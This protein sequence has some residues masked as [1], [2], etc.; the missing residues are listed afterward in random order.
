MKRNTFSVFFFLRKSRVN[1]LGESPIL[2]RITVNGISQESVIHRNVRQEVWNQSAERAKGNDRYSF[3]IN[4]YVDTV[5]TRIMQIHRQM[6]LDGKDITAREIK[7]TFQGNGARPKM[8]LDQFRKHNDQCRRLIDTEY[9]PATV[10]RFD[11]VVRYLGEFMKTLYRIEDI[12]FKEINH[13]FI[14]NYAYFLKTEKNLGHN[15]VVKQLKCLKKITR[16]AQ[17]NDWINKDPF[18]NYKLRE[19]S[20]ERDFLEKEEIDLILNRQLS[21]ERLEQVRDV[22]IFCAFTGLAF[23]DVKHLKP[24]HLVKGKGGE[25]WLR[26]ARQKTKN[27]CDI[28]LLQI[29]IRI[30]EKYRENPKCLKQG[31]L[32]PVLCN[33]RMNG[34]LKEIADLCG[35]RKNL[36]THM[37]RHTFATIALTHGMS[38]ESVA[39]MLGHSRIEQTKHYARILDS[40]ISKEMDQLRTVFDNHGNVS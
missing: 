3:E 23:T 33:Q 11:R 30:L 7:E 12:M 16:M 21:V 27:M 36:T 6:E 5:R 14:S 28:P 4:A 2:V 39:K 34:Y 40:K 20:T 37:A 15:A 18:M 9:S 10:S 22:F 8:L 13:E 1:K 38:I 17:M 24:E 29:P 25:L 32:L 31:V 26:I 35:I 19:K